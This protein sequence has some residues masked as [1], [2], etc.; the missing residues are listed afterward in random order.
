MSIYEFIL[1]IWYVLQLAF[2]PSAD[3][4][5]VPESEMLFH[6]VPVNLHVTLEAR[7]LRA[8]RTQYAEWRENNRL[9]FERAS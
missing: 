9:L 6:Q 3:E 1:A 7:R 5:P 8:L 4:T 2:Q